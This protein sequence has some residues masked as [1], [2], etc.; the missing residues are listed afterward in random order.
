MVA[1]GLRSVNSSDLGGVCLYDGPVFTM[2]CNFLRVQNNKRMRRIIRQLILHDEEMAW[3][4]IWFVHSVADH[5][6]LPGS[7]P[8]VEQELDHKGILEGFAA[9]SIQMSSW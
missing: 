3:E 4:K 6:I 2:P 5:E 9:V 8:V 1:V 7:L